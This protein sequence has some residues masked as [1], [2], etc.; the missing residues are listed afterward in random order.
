MTYTT[1]KYLLS[2]STY[3]AGILLQFNQS[4]SLTYED[5][6][7]G[8]GM[9]PDLLRQ[10]LELLLKQKI[11]LKEDEV[12]FELNRNFKSPKVSSVLGPVKARHD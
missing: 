1:P 3:Q 7:T 8:T 10:N 2:T 6:L 9:S 12:T 4:D 5:L 11:L